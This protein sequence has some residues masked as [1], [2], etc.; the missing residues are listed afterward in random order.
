MSQATTTADALVFAISSVPPDAPLG[1]EKRRLEVLLIQRRFPPYSQCWALPGGFLE[2]GEDPLDACLRELAEETGLLLT[3]AQAVPL[4]KRDKFR[5]DPRGTVTTWPFYFVLDSSFPRLTVAG[6]DA[7]Q[8]TWFSLE[9]LPPLAFDHGAIINE[10]L[11]QFF[12]LGSDDLSHLGAMLPTP[13]APPR[14]PWPSSV[15]FYGGSF[16]PFHSGHEA[17]IQEYLCSTDIPLV[18]VPDHNPWKME[19][20]DQCFFQ[21]LWHLAA[22]IQ[23]PNTYLYPGFWGKQDGNPTISWLTQVRVEN[24]Y[25]LMGDDSFGNLLSWQQ[26][27][28]LLGALAGIFVVPRGQSLDEFCLQK[29]RVLTVAPHLVITRPNHHAFEDLA[30]GQ[31]RAAAKGGLV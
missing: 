8:A 9:Q 23:R 19:I 2:L 3:R 13:L 28:D 1:K 22:K 30:S 16:N 25:L 4:S 6:D 26:A 21:N 24:K 20:P 27:P 29:D 14:E 17:C 7:S 11:G 31:I 15:T 18:V 10:A 12:G 5:R